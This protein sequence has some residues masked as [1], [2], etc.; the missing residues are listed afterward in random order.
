MFK[1]T[2]QIINEHEE[3]ALSKILHLLS[4]INL[5]EI[6]SNKIDLWTHISSIAL[7]C[8]IKHKKNQNDKM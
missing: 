1:S 6:N 2:E 8:A 4:E 5:S 7:S 3:L